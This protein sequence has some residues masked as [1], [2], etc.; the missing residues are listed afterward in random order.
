MRIIRISINVVRAHDRFAAAFARLDYSRLE[1]TPS[2]RYHVCH[3]VQHMVHAG[4][5]SEAARLYG[6]SLELLEARVRHGFRD[7]L[8]HDY[9]EMN[10]AGCGDGDALRMKAF[11]GGLWEAFERYGSSSVW[12]YAVQQPDTTA[13]CRSAVARRDKRLLRWLNKPSSEDPWQCECRFGYKSKVRCV[14]AVDGYFMVAQGRSLL[15]YDASS[16][17]LVGDCLLYTSPSPRDS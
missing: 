17:E 8:T 16:E 3:G 4:R 6:G 10:R 13:V 15:V 7:A 9:I 1:E 14:C 2:S 11:A 12:Q 5:G